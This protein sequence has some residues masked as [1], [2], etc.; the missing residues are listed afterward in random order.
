MLCIAF[1]KRVL[2]DLLDSGSAKR[3]LIYSGPGSAM[4]IYVD[5]PNFDP[6]PTSKRRRM[7][8]PHQTSALGRHASLFLGHGI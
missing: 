7:N 3:Q 4:F 5:L 8:N 1:V 2:V 6:P